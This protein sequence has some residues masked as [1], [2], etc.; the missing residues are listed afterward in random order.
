LRTYGFRFAVSAFLKPTSD[1]SDDFHNLRV[2]VSRG[3]ASRGAILVKM[4]DKKL[5]FCRAGGY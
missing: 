5:L 2:P 1:F 3:L 4:T